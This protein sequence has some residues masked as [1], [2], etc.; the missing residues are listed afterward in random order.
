MRTTKERLTATVDRELVRAGKEAVAAGRAAS[1]SGWVNA[2]LAERAAKDRRLQAMVQAVAAYEAERGEISAA[3]LAAQIAKMDPYRFE[4]LV[5]DLLFAMGYGG[6]REEAAKVTKKSGD[7][8]I[9]GVI[10]EDRLA[11]LL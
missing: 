5:V 11:V 3:E 1:L 9:D 6:S 4:Q 10:N 2:A 8:G 7:E